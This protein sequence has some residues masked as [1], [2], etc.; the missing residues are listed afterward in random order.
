MGQGTFKAASPLAISDSDA[1]CENAT[2]AAAHAHAFAHSTASETSPAD[3][4][5]IPKSSIVALSNQRFAAP[6]TS[7]IG[8]AVSEFFN[9]FKIS[10]EDA[11]SAASGREANIIIP[12]I[13]YL[14]N[15]TAKHT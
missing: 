7:A 5:T 6:M 13:S 4:F 11:I 15:E 8:T 2:A 10:F 14:G 12:A 1:H 3:I 9:D